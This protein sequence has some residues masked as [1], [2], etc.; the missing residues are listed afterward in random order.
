MVELSEVL[1]HVFVIEGFK[2]DISLGAH[3]A[4]E[5][6]RLIVLC[7]NAAAILSSSDVVL[8]VCFQIASAALAKNEL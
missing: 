7:V 8:T 1:L 5:V 3:K 2:D 6:A 4:V